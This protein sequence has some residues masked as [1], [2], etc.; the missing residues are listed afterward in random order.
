MT[1]KEII[2][3][4]NEVFWSD[5][6]KPKWHPEKGLFKSNNTTKIANAV[7]EASK[8]LKQAVSRI[9]FYYNRAGSNIPNGNKL[10]ASIIKKLHVKFSKKD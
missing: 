10:R 4:I 3:L 7:G 5:K 1:A 9:N 2:Y 6:V 8:N